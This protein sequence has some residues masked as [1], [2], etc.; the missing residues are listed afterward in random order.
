MNKLKGILSE[1]RRGLR[2]IEDK[3][4]DFLR[5]NKSQIIWLY[6]LNLP[7]VYGIGYAFSKTFST[8]YTVLYTILFLWNIL[9][10]VLFLVYLSQKHIIIKYIVNIIS[11]IMFFVDIFSLFHYRILFDQAML[12][13]ILETNK[14][15]SLEFLSSYLDTDCL[16]VFFGMSILIGILYR[17]LLKA[18][19]Y[20]SKVEK[21][22]KFLVIFSVDIF[23]LFFFY[24]PHHYHNWFSTLQF[25]SAAFR[26]ALLMPFSIQNVYEC[27]EVL[28]EMDAR[29]IDFK[30]NDSTIPN[31][32]FIL[33]ESTTRR[34]MGIYGYELDTTPHM[35]ERKQKNELVMF[36]DVISPE[37]YTIG[38]VR[39]LFTFFSNDDD[40][41]KEKE[42]YQYTNLLTILRQ[43]GY[44]TVWISN[45]ESAGVFGNVSRVCA[46]LCD[47]KYY[48][49]VHDSR[50]VSYIK[51]EE[52]FPILD[53]V[54]AASSNPKNFYVL[55]LMG[56]H[57]IYSKR[58]PE[59]YEV[60]QAK[61]ETIGEDE[62][63][64]KKVAEYDNAVLYNDFI[65]DSIIQR[66]EKENAIVIYISDHGEAVY[67]TGT[68]GHSV[69]G[70]NQQKEIPMLIWM[71]EKFKAKYPYLEQRIRAADKLPFMTDNMIHALLDLMEIETEEC[72][73]SKS[74]FH[75][76]FDKER[77]RQKN[78]EV[79]TAEES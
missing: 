53:R 55:H 74:L 56:T 36:E 73:A 20:Y 70:G 64:R 44:H 31:V 19:R 24:F 26:V 12:L 33:G 10:W 17:V 28:R 67:E 42:W 2:I 41:N 15:E 51:D 1:F 3:I 54:L 75:P 43:A 22:G 61:D 68:S 23:I 57:G 35:E 50:T 72:D 78:G 63:Q 34:H 30:K 11:V 48:T 8:G 49:L 40:D 5:D 58:Y 77:I 14:R 21:L 37:T 39:K 18:T 46:D 9:F 71:S 62:G 7:V 29:K 32:V 52:I 59:K 4:P 38:V 76:S 13:V 27:G 65:V 79:Y 60:F 6:L 47:E 25:S 66:F 16:G 45:Q 69:S